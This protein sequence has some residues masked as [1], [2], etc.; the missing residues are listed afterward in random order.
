LGPA[1]R[2][3]KLLQ[4]LGNAASGIANRV[5]GPVGLDMGAETPEE[6]ALSIMAGIHVELSGRTGQQLNAGAVDELHECIH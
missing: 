5:F 6:I 3:E 4:R 2:K 1:H